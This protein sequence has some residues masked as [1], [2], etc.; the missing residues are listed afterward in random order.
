MF[1]FWFTSGK[2]RGSQ[3]P[4]TGIARVHLG[5]SRAVQSFL[6]FTRYAGAAQMMHK[7]VISN[8]KVHPLINQF[9]T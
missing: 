8:D 6:A 4:E 1:D 3:K 5:K 2:P 7:N 9:E